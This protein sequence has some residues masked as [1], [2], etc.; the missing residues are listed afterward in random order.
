MVAV[1][2]MRMVPWAVVEL[3]AGAEASELVAVLE[4]ALVEIAAVV[5]EQMLVADVVV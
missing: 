2:A 4:L 1:R 5:L 3:L